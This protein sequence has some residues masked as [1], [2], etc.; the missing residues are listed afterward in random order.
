M[1]ASPQPPCGSDAVL[2]PVTAP[3]PGGRAHAATF[4]AAIAATLAVLLAAGGIA[5]DR[6]MFRLGRDTAAL[7]RDSALALKGPAGL[8]QDVPT[9][10]GVVAVESITKSAGPTAKALAGVTHGIQS[11]VPPNKVGIEAAVT[12]TNLK[13]QPQPY[14]P[15]QFRL[16]ATKSG[17]PGSG[18]KPIRP[19]RASVQ[20]G[21]LQPDAS[22]DATL[23]FTAPRNGAKL[24]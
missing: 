1:A 15:D 9:S 23:T 4:L 20:P 8:A 18:D 6:G 17:R 14:S 5:V 11:L 21:T 13:A 24:W 10:F 19:S 12:M 2:V 16:F 3:A 22:V 7:Q